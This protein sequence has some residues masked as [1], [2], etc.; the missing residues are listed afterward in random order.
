MDAK[1][2][3]DDEKRCSAGKALKTKGFLHLY[4]YYMNLPPHYGKFEKR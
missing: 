2:H 1:I 3:Q 4:A